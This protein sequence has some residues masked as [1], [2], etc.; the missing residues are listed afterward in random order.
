[1]ARIEKIDNFTDLVAFVYDPDT[2]PSAIIKLKDAN[3]SVH[4]LREAELG[5]LEKILEHQSVKVDPKT[6]KMDVEARAYRFW[7]DYPSLSQVCYAHHFSS[8][9]NS[10]KLNDIE[11]WAVKTFDMC[12]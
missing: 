8:K 7:E 9:L 3:I 4:G 10:R 5:V 6:G 11:E 12:A 1:M 2:L